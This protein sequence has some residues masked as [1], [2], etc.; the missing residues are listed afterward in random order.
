MESSLKLEILRLLLEAGEENLPTILNTVLVQHSSEPPDVLL[1][2]V[3]EALEAI[4][5]QSYTELAWYKDGWIALIPEERQLV[6]PLANSV[7]W[8]PAT[9]QWRWKE[10]ELGPERPIVILTSKGE[11]YIR[12]VLRE[13]SASER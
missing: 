5:K 11:D 4:E 13:E 2:S 1:A 3:G 9:N 10:E 6:L 7:A 8:D 12:S